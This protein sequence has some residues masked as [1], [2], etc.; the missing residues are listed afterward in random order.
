[1]SWFDQAIE[2]LARWFKFAS[3][4]K[5]P[6]SRNAVS[7]LAVLPDGSEGQAISQIAER[8]KWHVDIVSTCE[9]AVE[10][11]RMQR[12]TVIL[13]DRD[14]PGF[15]W[16]DVV[17]ILVAN[18]PRSCVILTSPVNDDYL[19]Q[20]VIQHGGY[21]VLTKPFQEDRVVSTI[22]FASRDDTFADR[23]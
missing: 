6:E 2:N 1:M 19:W 14:L 8:E 16:R 9:V 20:E 23:V 12:F 17:E 21:D 22:R 4:R 15:N 10:R 18:A 13:C 3:T 11:L 7:V 5:S